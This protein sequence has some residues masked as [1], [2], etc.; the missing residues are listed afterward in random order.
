[1]HGVVVGIGA[2]FWTDPRTDDIVVHDVNVA[3]RR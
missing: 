1:M 3:G 2:L